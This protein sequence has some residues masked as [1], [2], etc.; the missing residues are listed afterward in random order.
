MKFWRSLKDQHPI[1]G[2]LW[3]GW[4]TLL[5][6]TLLWDASPL[7]LAT[8]DLIGTVNGFPLQHQT[9]LEIWL[10]DRL[11]IVGWFI[12]LS[13]WAWAFIR[14][15]SPI[16]RRADRVF[17]MA[18]VT[19][20]LLMIVGLKHLSQ[21]SCPWSVQNWGGTVGYVSHWQWGIASGGGDHCFPSGH[22]SSAWAFVPLVLA[23][24]WPLG[25]RVRSAALPWI[26]SAFAIGVVLTAITQTLRG[27]HYPSHSLWTGVICTGT[28]LMAW[29]IWQRRWASRQ[30]R[31][32]RLAP[33]C[34][35]G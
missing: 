23:A 32:R 30:A 34:D 29:T 9:L 33:A 27:A 16:F 13:G 26:S 17:L 18:M 11:R 5:I 2:Y 31:A 25:G 10:H 14:K 19:V 4:L 35:Q 22:A 6:L 21:T 8:M 24:W 12:Y 1:A 7:D 28:S 3:R 20:N 15:P